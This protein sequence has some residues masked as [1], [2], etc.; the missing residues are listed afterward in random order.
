VLIR[1][2]W[3]TGECAGAIAALPAAGPLPSRTV[4]IRGEAMAHSVRRDMLRAGHAGGLAGTRFL[5]PPAAAAAVLEAAGIEVTPG[6][7]ALRRARL[8]ALFRRDLSR[9]GLP[10]AHFPPALLRDRP[11]W[12]DAF[13]QTIGALEAAGLRP[14]MLDAEGDAR[15]RDVAGAWRSLDGLAAA[16][17]TTARILLEAARVLEERPAIW[18]FPGPTL[19]IATGHESNAHA[20]FLRAIPDVTLALLAARPLR[21]RHMDRIEAL[22]GPE[23]RAALARPAPRASATERD[24]LAS[25]LFEPPHV[26]AAADRS[27]SAGPDDTVRLEEHAGIEG[28]VEATAD[29]VA[30]QV[31]DGIPLEDIAVL[32]P[33]IDPVGA[34]VAERLARLPYPG[35]ALPVHVARGLP[36]AGTA[37]GAR[38]LAVVRALR[39]YLSG[40]ALAEVLPA[41]R[42]ASTDAV[43]SP[44]AI[45]SPLAAGAG[46][47]ADDRAEDSSH[48]R[49]LSHGAATD[50]VWALGTAGGNAAHPEAALEWAA[51]LAARE[52]RIEA[53]LARAR[54]AGDEPER[55]GLARTAR[56]LER[57]LG[58]L[59]AARAAIEA[60]AEIARLV[61]R[62][63]SLAA[64]WPPLRDFL[65]Q[66]LL[67]PGAGPRVHAL[68]DERLAT[69][70]TDPACGALTGDDALRVVED[71]IA[72]L[73]L[74]AGRFG[75]PAVYVGSLAG[76][77]GLSFAA[78]RVIG[79]AE[80][81]LPP[82]VREDPVVPDALRE[83]LRVPALGGTTVTPATAEARALQML[84]ALDA[85]I[86]DSTRRVALSAPRLDLDRSQREP[87]SVLLEAAAAL[88]RPSAVT[89]APAAA[90]P[91][92]TA[93]RRDAF[94]PA[95]RAALDFRLARPL[96]QSAWQDAVARGAVGVPP[97]WAHARALDLDRLAM[98]TDPAHV[99]ALDGL[100]GA[101]AADIAVPGITAAWP[102]SPSR[103]QTLLQCPHHFLFE[104]L[105]G[106]DEP[107]AA[108][109]LWEIEQPAYGG[110]FHSVAEEFFRAH[111][112]AFCAGRETPE[113]WLAAAD[114]IVDG[115]FEA[116]IEQYPLLGLAVRGAQRQRLREDL[117]DLV[118]YEWALGAR[119]FVATER[120]FGEP[121]PVELPLA[122]RSLFVRGTMDRIDADGRRTLVRDLKTGRVSAR[123]GKATEPDHVGDV[124]IAVYG[125][126]AERRARE[127]NTPAAVGVAYVGRHGEVRDFIGDFATVLAPAARAW[128]GLAADLL[129]RR[130]F[131]RTP[132]A[133]DCTYCAFRPVCGERVYERAGRVLAEGDEPLPQLL[134][135]KQ[136]DE[137][138]EGEDE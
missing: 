79:L 91:D 100:L 59:R 123:R 76:A 39:A 20:R 78:T 37:A 56:D 99:T 34:L 60:L 43:A 130:A 45:G 67:Q 3:T 101:A 137:R 33:A 30:E 85:V 138:D 129:S 122:G 38:A 107:S 27:R 66:W 87:S 11:G 128:L 136:P 5:S 86:R 46:L 57:L 126:V 120:S 35:G 125:L 15:L 58:D 40:D 12:D 17:W 94:V 18:P 102:I 113:H 90:I 133:G 73:R 9:G 25:Y 65:A 124:Q 48:V 106:F 116:F 108:P 89:G 115:M 31:A 6:E 92:T 132:D 70:T 80:G 10:L 52:P 36:L 64:L 63:A 29:W 88:G 69:A 47:P 32:M 61:V 41:L 81:H 135:L 95:R 8:L 49:H 118:R 117:R 72:S 84:H 74:R 1:A 96:A 24:L 121:A 103:L 19:A 44:G 83:R 134:A 53:E 16:S 22:Y 109:A 54:A 14:E 93:L 127:W 77:V 97:R 105:L 4:L 26:L 110:L 68:L 42:A 7:E 50:L 23:A 114:P 28:E 131:P 21:E 119:R 71:A 75:E 2:V 112:E 55:A 104:T 62:R 13:A 111:G 82:L 51:R 98:L